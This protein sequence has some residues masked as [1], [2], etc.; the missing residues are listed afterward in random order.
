MTQIWAHR[1]SSAEA[2]ENTLEAFDLAIRQG[3]DAIELD[4]Q[5]SADGVVVVCHDETI[6][7]TTDGTGP[8]AAMTL[9]QLQQYNIPTLAEVYDLVADSELRVN[10]E[11]KNSLVDYPGLEAAAEA[12]LAGSR[13]ANQTRERIIYSSF[14]H[15]SL[16]TLAASGTSAGLGVLY[17]ERLVRSWEYARS[18]GAT[19]L[20]PLHLSIDADEVS[21]A[22]E[23]GLAVHPWTVDDP[24][25]LRTMIG[26]GVDAVIT[27][28]PLVAR[29]V[30]G[31]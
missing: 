18:F 26:F 19:A 28:Q 14:N 16:A 5:L 9:A 30:L 6:D 31:R 7:R 21:A 11:L 13:L 15:R 22:H 8:I 17:V 25:T 23:A 2:P 10:V 3:A 24:D 12:T 4:V 1:G 20:H 29:E 27:N